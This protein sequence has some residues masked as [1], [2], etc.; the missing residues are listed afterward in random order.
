ML[1]PEF[2]PNNLTQ[3]LDREL[4]L[5]SIEI[6]VLPNLDMAIF[7]LRELLLSF[8]RPDCYLNSWVMSGYP[9]TT[10][11]YEIFFWFASTLW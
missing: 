6:V 2:G 8:T 5:L 11:S 9:I 3:Q 7:P 10:R 1:Y 4:R